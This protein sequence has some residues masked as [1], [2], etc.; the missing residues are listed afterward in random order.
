M[1]LILYG[2]I[3][4][5]TRRPDH[6]SHLTLCTVSMD[7]TLQII[8]DLSGSGKEFVRSEE[9]KYSNYK[10]IQQVPVTNVTK[11]R[12]RLVKDRTTVGRQVKYLHEKRK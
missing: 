9:I 12:K 6:R 4:R 1:L 2:D 7:Y 10:I 8:D 3:A 5:M 11:S